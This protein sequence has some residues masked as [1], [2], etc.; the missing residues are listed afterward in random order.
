MSQ[1]VI[2]N[3]EFTDLEKKHWRVWT[4][5]K[6]R[7]LIDEEIAKKIH[8]THRTVMR[9]KEKAR[10]NGA[11]QEWVDSQVDWATEENRVLH[12]DIKRLNPFLA[13][14]ETNKV[15]LKN[16]TGK[17]QSQTEVD[18]KQR[19]EHVHFDM[20]EDEDATLCRAAR[21]LDKKLREKNETAKIH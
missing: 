19:V 18:I 5:G 1:N 9:L 13:Y 15:I 3:S 7:G 4:E 11:F 2:P 20:T 8:R 17:I 21:I 12:E 6:N 14:I 16:M 10:R